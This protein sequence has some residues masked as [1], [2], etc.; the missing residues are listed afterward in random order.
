M[1]QLSSLVAFLDRTL[2]PSGYD[3]SCQNGLQIES[4][5]TEIKKIGLAVDSG[6]SVFEKAVAA[7]CQLLIVHHGLFW[8]GVPNLNG[9]LGKKIRLMIENGCS[10]YASHLP[11]DGHPKFGNNAEIIRRL[12]AKIS[13][14]FCRSGIKHAGFTAELAKTLTQEQFETKLRK[15]T[16][17]DRFLALNFGKRKIKSFAIVTG[18]A[19]FAIAEAKNCGVDAFIT[20]EPKQSAYHEAHESGLNVYFGGH[21]STET[22]GVKAIGLELEKKFRIATEF[23]DVPTRI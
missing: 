5:R 3:D 7:N 4:S 1:T 14:P 23:I 21:Y 22:F 2:D 13:G 19:A 17:D 8:G 15:I 9:M 20:G 18:S 10:L 6:L 12:G 11:L 16:L